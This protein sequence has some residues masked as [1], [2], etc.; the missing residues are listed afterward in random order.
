MLRTPE[1]PAVHVRPGFRVGRVQRLAGCFIRQVLHD[2]ARFPQVEITI[3]QHGNAVVG[4][5]V[6]E[7]RQMLVAFLQVDEHQFH[8]GFELQGGHGGGPGVG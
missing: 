2:G 5:H 6:E 8:G 1:Q 7:L 3:L 4:V